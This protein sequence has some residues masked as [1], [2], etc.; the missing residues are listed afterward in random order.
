MNISD[1]NGNLT[2]RSDILRNNGVGNS[3]QVEPSSQGASSTEARDAGDRVEISDDARDALK[4]A[5]KAEE[6][7][8]ARKALGNLPSLSEER[9]EELADRIKSGYYQQHDVLEKVA[10]RAGG[11][12]KTDL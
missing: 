4:D 8:F 7:I 2:H 9:I 1:I 5:R 12:L 3:G 10:Q 11:A 6:L